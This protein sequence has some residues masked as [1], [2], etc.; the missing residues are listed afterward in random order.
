MWRQ[1]AKGVAPKVGETSASHL[2]HLH[3][4]NWE[5]CK[6]GTLT[7]DWRRFNIV[8][9]I[10]NVNCFLTRVQS[11]LPTRSAGTDAATTYRSCPALSTCSREEKS[12]KFESSQAFVVLNHSTFHIKIL[13]TAYLLICFFYHEFYMSGEVLD[14]FVTRTSSL[15]CLM[16]R[17]TLP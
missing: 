3:A 11:S 12:K 5:D 6:K 15:H 8:H 13:F 7:D 9:N 10:H 16:P 4:P 1:S 14:L 2:T 17:D